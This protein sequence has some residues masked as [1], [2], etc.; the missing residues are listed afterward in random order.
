MTP[1]EIARV[2]ASLHDRWFDVDGISFEKAGCMSIPFSSNTQWKPNPDSMD[3]ELL[4][5]NVSSFEILDDAQIR[6]YDFNVLSYDPN[7]QMLTISSGC[8]IEIHV[9]V[10]Q[11]SL[12]IRPIPGRL[13]EEQRHHP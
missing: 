13:A 1:D 4:I 3:S 8:P 10:D 5:A 9:V 7:A 11:L 12:S 2:S 6:F